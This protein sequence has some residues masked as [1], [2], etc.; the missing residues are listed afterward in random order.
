MRNADVP[1]QDLRRAYPN[2][3]TT[4][5][6]SLISIGALDRRPPVRILVRV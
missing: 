3:A 6:F 1:S 5:L 4:I 2:Y